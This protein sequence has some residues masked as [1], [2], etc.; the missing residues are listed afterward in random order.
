MFVYDC[1]LSKYV[2][3]NIYFIR[4]NINDQDDVCRA[5]KETF[6]VYGI[7]IPAT[8]VQVNAFVHSDMR[9]EIEVDAITSKSE[10]TMSNVI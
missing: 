5:F 1:A 10:T 7:R 8:L 9:V 2:K 6:H 4:I 3:S